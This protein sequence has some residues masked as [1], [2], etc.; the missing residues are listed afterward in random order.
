MTTSPRVFRNRALVWISAILAWT[1][2]APATLRADARAER[3][4]EDLG[5]LAT[6]LVVRHPN[7]Y[8]TV[9]KESFDRE[10]AVLDA[11]IPSLT[12]SEVMVGLMR[13]TALLGDGHTNIWLDYAAEAVGMKFFPWQLYWFDDGLYVIK[14]TPASAEAQGAKVLTIGG[15]DVAAVERLVASTI[16]HE[17]DFWLHEVSPSHMASL[18]ILQALKILPAGT[19]GTFGLEG[20][21]G[22]RFS[23]ELE[24]VPWPEWRSL[25]SSSP[26][27]APTQL[28]LQHP[29]LNYWYE[30]LPQERVL[31]FQYNACREQ[32]GRPL[33]AFTS[34]LLSFVDT[35]PVDRIILDLRYNSGGNS[36]LIG[37][38]LAGLKGRG[39]FWPLGRAA[40]VIGRK[41]FSAGL[42]NSMNLRDAGV[43][44]IGEP[45]GGKPNAY[46][47]V[48]SFTL[49]R[50][51]V[52]VSYS[53]RF[54]HLVVGDPAA[55]FPDFAFPPRATDYFGGKDQA[56]DAMVAG[57]QPP[58][59]RITEPAT[60]RTV[61]AGTVVTFAGSGA[62][63]DPGDVL[64]YSWSFGDGGAAEG[65]S[66]RHS[67]ALPGT[68][69][70]VLTVRDRYGAP[71]TAWVQIQVVEPRVVGAE[72]F[73]PVVMDI[74]GVGGSHFTTELTLLA[75]ESQPP[76][77]EQ[78]RV[79]LQYT[80]ASGGGS[81]YT[82][83]TLAPGELRVIPDAIAFLRSRGLA[84][85][86]DV[87]G[88]LGTLRAT[89][90]GTLP[91]DAF[92]GG[93]TFTPGAGGTFGLFYP[94][95]RLTSATATIVGLQEHSGQRSNVALQNGGTTP[96]TLRVHFF[97]PRGEDLGTLD[98]VL[99]AY[100]F[101]QVNR[102]LLGKAEAGRA[103]VT[104]VAGTAPFHAY[105]VLNDA[106]TS[107]GSFLPP[108]VPSSETGA[109]RLV[110]VVLD[111]YGL[112]GSHYTSELTLTNLSSTALPLTLVYTAASGS[113]SGAVS[114]TLAAGEQRILPDTIAFLREGGLAIPADGSAV[115]GTLLVQ[116]PS[117]ASANGLAAGA[118]TFTPA[119]G[120]EGTFGLYYPGLT[121]DECAD[122]VAWVNGLQQNAAMRS[123]LAVVN[124]GDADDAV[125]LRVTYFGSAG[126]TLAN[127]DDVTLR[128]GEWRQFPQPLALRGATAGYAKVERLSGSS[129]FAAY[130][131]LNDAGTSD[132]SY[133]PMSF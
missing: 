60:D 21:D 74:G 43:P 19:R 98:Q 45:T 115:V 38:L 126:N 52:R 24:T 78:I 128:P 105:G 88:A 25:R 8:F 26:V 119:P 37:P 46:S 35:H 107:D 69:R 70:V 42:T 82:T 86:N 10:V 94:G 97:G 123:N 85:P 55:M 90:S 50:S 76:T 29:E 59:A 47:E 27:P 23:L 101:A 112:G 102:P 89:F 121:R 75:R 40:L 58:I 63:P 79:L 117:G 96:I 13:V 9:S 17:N 15:M 93:R 1:A 81:G 36:S 51:G 72:A 2:L 65:A 113:G 92:I 131:V 64:T 106:I 56:V 3:W 39:L 5:T 77:T 83:E 66:V 129:R 124:R 48:Q 16:S 116:A 53:T 104:R 41:T 99:G 108:A 30:Y 14:T 118:R 127:P 54:Y 87:A 20:P 4:R 6:Q 44:A 125:S 109:D 18:D 100:G 95:A 91:A 49:P 80:A 33:A 11:A 122:R 130:G 62:D 84:I 61:D 12:D 111:A 22:T 31:Y 110:P 28:H 7:P 114:V 71:D 73:L 57:D 103:V 67:F 120:G 34:E 68:Y 132:G 133:L 32:P